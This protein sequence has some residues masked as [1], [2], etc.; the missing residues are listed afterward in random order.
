MRK[1]LIALILLSG[2][3][4]VR[5]ET[6]LRA[7]LNT[8]IASSDPRGKRDENTDS[9][10]LHVV[11]G[12]VASRDDGSI[13]PMLASRWTIS[14]DGRTYRF[15]LR[16]D[17]R[18]HNGAPLTS[19]D[20]VWSFD[21][22]MAADSHWRCK[23]E[24]G[25]KGIAGL[26]SVKAD[27]PDVVVITLD[28]AAPLFLKTIARADCGGTGILQSASVAPDGRWR[29]PIGT[30]PFR[31]GE[32]V[33]NQ[34]VDLVRFAGY[35]S[36]PGR[37]NGNGGGKHALV[38]RIRFQVIPDGSAASAALLRGSLDVLDGLAPNELAGLTGAPGIRFTSSPTMD[39]YG[40][41]FQTQDPLLADPR[42]RRA[43]AL[44]IDVAGLA[45]VAT[46]G[47][48]LADSSPIPDASPF[49]GTVEK[50]LTRKD[51]PLVRAL[52]R[53]S[54]Y[55]GQTID[56][57]TSHSPPEMFD[58]AVLLQAMAREAGIAMRI[59]TLDWASQLARYQRGDYQAMLFGF[60]AR[61]DP[62][63][64]YGTMIG[65]KAS[66]PRK[67][68]DTSEARALYQQS[69]ETADPKARQAIFDRMEVAWHR[70]VPAAVLYNSRRVTAYRSDVFGYESW[71]AQ[72][73][74]L[75]DVGIRR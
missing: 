70:D 18:F 42:L 30:G 22:Y 36:L 69:V 41:L 71:P 62:S 50:P 15:V 65:N 58:D 39:F 52:V 25:S 40:L 13:G 27:G 23:P 60:S 10:L 74:R 37:R 55:K 19:A 31:W 67:I 54:G 34:H 47:T 68:W 38:D 43:I 24:L 29:M 64:I 26:L 73:Q 28:R 2:T 56:L 5:A 12:L 44:S 21:R 66:D 75:W 32:W 9:V 17:V 59:V 57:I 35:R 61:L 20:V 46:H 33:R 45:R 14:P 3:A 11:E 48:A 1:A 51:L 8:D 4:P 6:L 53:E 63:L 72:L 16:P 49:H 7:R